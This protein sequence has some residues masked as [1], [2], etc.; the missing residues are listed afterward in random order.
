MKLILT[1]ILTILTTLAIAQDTNKVD[2]NGKKQGEP[3][4]VRFSDT[5]GKNPLMGRKVCL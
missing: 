3:P 5:L 2:A 1:I 4:Q